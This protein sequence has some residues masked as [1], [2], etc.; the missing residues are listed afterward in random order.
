MIDI[1]LAASKMVTLQSFIREMLDAEMQLFASSLT[2]DITEIVT[3]YYS[4]GGKKL[5]PALF[6]AVANAFK[7]NEN[8]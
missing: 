5:R 8:L 4:L 7:A 1:K 2:P 3:Y 6:L